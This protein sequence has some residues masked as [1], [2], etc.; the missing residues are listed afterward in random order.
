MI[1]K[2]KADIKKI[3]KL[4]EEFRVGLHRSKTAYAKVEIVPKNVRIQGPIF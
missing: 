2:V 4:G 1:L 3:F